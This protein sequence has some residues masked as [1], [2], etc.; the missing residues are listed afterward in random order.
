M[1]STES[2]NLCWCHWV[3]YL[4]FW[5]HKFLV[6]HH[7]NLD[8]WVLSDGNNGWKPS[9][10]KFYFVG[11]TCFEN[12]VTKTEWYDPKSPSSKQAQNDPTLY[13]QLCTVWFGEEYIYIYIYICFFFLH[14]FS[15]ESENSNLNLDFIIK[16][17]EPKYNVFVTN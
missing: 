5:K 17:L 1:G 3:M 15:L 9:Q 8:F 13:D 4:S 12:L 16:Q 7:S 11:P 6:F 2:E 10:T 14:F